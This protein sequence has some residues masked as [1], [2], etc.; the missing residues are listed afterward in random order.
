MA[1]LT[2]YLDNEVK[3]AGQ[4]KVQASSHTTAAAAKERPADFN[5]K[6][7]L[8]IPRL[9]PD[10]YG[11]V[12]HPQILLHQVIAN[13]VIHHMINEN[14]KRNGQP[15]GE[16]LLTIDT[17][18][19]PYVPPSTG[20]NVLKY[21][22]SEPG[23][24]VKPGTE[25][26]ILCAG[27]SITVGYLSDRNGGD[28]NGYR[29]Q[30]RNDLSKDKVSYAGTVSSGT[31]KDGYYAA[32]SGKTIQYISDHIGP[33]LKHR[34]N[35]ILLHAGTNDMNPNTNIATEGNEP[36][37]AADRLG[38]LID[39]MIEACPDA[40]ILVAMIVN[41]CDPNQSGRTKEYQ[42]LVPGVVKARRESGHHV[43]AADFTSFP[44][45]SLQDCIHPTNDGYHL[46]GDYWYDF[47][48]QIPKDWIK[49]PVG[50][51]P[52][53]KGG[54]DSNGG[55]DG[56]IP[57]PDWGV[58]PV[59]AAAN[60]RDVF[61]SALLAGDGGRKMCKTTPHWYGTGKI[62][63]GGVGHNGKWHYNKDWV[64]AGEVASGLKRDP[65]Y[66][67]LHDMNGDGKADYVWLDP[68][69]GMLICWLNNLPEP[70]SPAGTND[71]IIGSGAGRAE[72]V[73]LA[74][75]NGDGMDDY[76]V[77]NPDTGAV[78]IWW[79]YG[80]DPDWVNGWKFV[81]GGEIASGVPHANWA[82]LRFPDI[83][84]DGRADYVYI[85]EGGALKHHMNTGSDGGQDVLFE[86]MG[87]IA[88]GAAS[89]ISKLIF[90]D[91]DGDGR[92]DYLI[93]DDIGGLTG[94]LNQPTNREGVPLYVDQGP[95]KT[96]ADG[97]TQ[98]P[99]FIHLAD[100]DGDGKD[101]YAYI[102]ANG[103]IQLWWN[104]GTA[105]TSM[106]IDGVRFADID[107]DGVDDYVWLDAA[108][109]APTVFVNKGPNTDDSLG[110]LWEPLNGGRPIASGAAPAARVQFGDIDGD[111]KDD[112]LVLDAKTGALDLY[113]NRG[114]DASRAERWRWEPVG[115]IATG[116]GPGAHVRFADIDGDG[117]DDYIFL[118]PGGRTTIYQNI[119]SSTPGP[120][121]RALPEADA[122]GIG[123]RPEE[124][125]FVDVDGDGRADYVWT[126]ALDGRVRVWL[127]D[128]PKL[129]TWRAQGEVAGGVGTAGSNIRW[130]QLQGT[131]RADYVAVD[132]GTG[133][134]AAWLNGCDALGDDRPRPPPKV[135]CHAGS[136]C[137][138]YKCP[139]G[140]KPRCPVLGGPAAGYCQCFEVDSQSHVLSNS[141]RLPGVRHNASSVLENPTRA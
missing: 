76:M 102:D 136:G 137:D 28:G 35:I 103:A 100:L 106:A 126:S 32:W 89:D 131:G 119:Y 97:I 74:D 115:Q 5:V 43:L 23:K 112:Y 12:F 60:K 4:S 59:Q 124:I 94:F 80:P 20:K 63:L 41:T 40:V 24:G 52:D 33:S 2:R 86:A 72:S 110:W 21:G 121:W 87:G 48:T 8:E 127:N 17:S 118:H 69:T 138:N 15:E 53:R 64:A 134:V 25:L 120:D 114:P 82:T 129:P 71:S 6:A 90:G 30:M 77:V 29:L 95:A 79:N 73:F 46:F 31:M 108:T 92:D 91:M 42:K 62:A 98:N 68:E 65:R 96:I 14:E 39:Q 141:T 26:R 109:G 75:M 133:A 122:A 55:L 93:W 83:N 139:E 125:E 54:I 13:L 85:G 88:T 140:K 135:E 38:K 10:G 45:D 18:S 16:E 67:R 56:G 111:G 123:Q 3:L 81:D 61:M 99:D 27:D 1:E 58:S 37:G 66:V 107:G 47:L 78:R 128:Y 34:P 50:A 36:A 116:L 117:M 70:W 51:D 44:V 22:H 105:D 130:A 132:P 84:G 9:L 104:R 49:D 101:D 19:C 57:A 11:R 113:L 7:L